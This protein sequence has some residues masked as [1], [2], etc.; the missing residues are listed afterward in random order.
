MSVSL[1]AGAPGRGRFSTRNLVMGL[2]F[3]I[4][5]TMALGWASPRHAAFAAFLAS[6]TLGAWVMSRRSLEGVTVERRHRARVFEEDV[7]PVGLVVRQSKGLAQTL[8]LVEDSFFASLSPRQRHLI[9]MMTPRWEAHLHYIKQAERHRGLYLLGPVHLWAADPLGIFFRHAEVDCITRLTVYPPTMELGGY[10]FLGPEPRAGAALENTPRVGQGE[11]IISVRPYQTGDPINR[12]HW[13]TSVRRRQLHTIEL[14]TTVQIEVALFLDLTR[15]S[16]FG[17]GSEST[18]E[19][20]I[21][22]AVSIL[23]EAANLRHR[24]SLTLTVDKVEHVPAGAGLAHLHLLLDRLAVVNPRGELSFWSAIGHHAALLARG[25]RAIIMAPA[26]TTPP[27]QAEALVRRLT[28]EGVAVDVVLIDES[29]LIRIHRDQV[30]TMAT[31]EEDFERLKQT[32]EQSG[33]R[34]MPIS[35]G[36]TAADLLPEAGEERELRPEMIQRR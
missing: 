35:R 29:N 25:S 10:R 17:T 33:A 18:A 1:E 14:D 30:P 16:L 31:A 36:D 2:L 19:M 13:R 22:C 3:T 9:P 27:N 20:A 21:G 7:V 15:R 8:V 11:E 24:V 6:A 28:L 5:A 12:I 23:S 34:V 32:L 26:T 4:M